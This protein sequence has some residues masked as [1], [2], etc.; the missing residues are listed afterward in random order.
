[1]ASRTESVTLAWDPTSAGQARELTAQ[2]C[3]AAG[4]TTELS[5]TCV[6]LTS[7]TVTNA[8]LHGRSHVRLTVI[9]GPAGVR[10]EVGDDNSR[11]PVLY[12]HQDLDA[13]NGRGILMIDA[14]ATAWG[15]TPEGCGKTVWF[16]VSPST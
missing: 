12:D 8:L 1:M 7:E 10:V 13:L 5:A 15:I 16:E 3:A 14:C 2:M 9:T 11:L 6:L 4:F